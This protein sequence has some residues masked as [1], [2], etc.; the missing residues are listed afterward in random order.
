[1][2][3]NSTKWML[4]D[5]FYTVSENIS[6]LFIS[7]F[8][9]Q[10]SQN[11]TI[12]LKYNL[13][14]FI[15]IPFI[16]IVASVITKNISYKFNIFLSLIAKSIVL[17]GV[18][19]FHQVFL[20]NP[21]L[22]GILSAIAIGLYAIP[23]NTITNTVINKNE[24]SKIT[25]FLESASS[26]MSL[27]IPIIGSLW[28]FL[29]GSY[30]T[31]FIVSLGILLM[32]SLI[33]SSVSI[34]ETT[35]NFS[36]TKMLMLTKNSDFLRLNLRTFFWGIRN[37]LSWSVFSIFILFLVGNN[38]PKWGTANTIMNTLVLILGLLYSKLLT[39]KQNI[40]KITLYLSSFIYTALVIILVANFNFI[41]LIIFLIIDAFTDLI[42]NSSMSP[43]TH[44]ILEEQLG[45]GNITSEFFT[46]VE[47]PLALGRVIPILALLVVNASF[48]NDSIIKLIILVMGA[49]PWITA[50][51]ISKN[52]NQY[53]TS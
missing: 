16:G 32:S 38:L 13:T 50:S 4:S 26:G 39:K 41:T 11:L 14:V 17:L 45:L 49:I 22:L 15:L 24:L 51:I 35:D 5:F 6:A 18:S 12:I 43:I 19:F 28:I 7:I 2:F 34:P 52:R 42:I 1:M 21:H 46:L 47:F 31:L 30:S 27:V 33:R 48:T 37:S 8:I 23:H 3:T 44:S 9:W 25:A 36:F 29:T 10:K 53:V 20:E 40:E